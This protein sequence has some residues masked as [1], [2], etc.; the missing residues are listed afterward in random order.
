MK[1]QNLLAAIA[2]AGLAGCAQKGSSPTTF[3]PEPP[4]YGNYGN[5]REQIDDVLSDFGTLQIVVGNHGPGDSRMEAY[6]LFRRFVV[7]AGQVGTP[8]P[9]VQDTDLTNPVPKPGQIYIGTSANN[10]MIVNVRSGPLPPTGTGVIEARLTPSG[11][12]GYLVITA[13]EPSD[14]VAATR[15]VAAYDR[16]LADGSIPTFDGS[17]FY[18]QGT[19]DPLVFTVSKQ[20]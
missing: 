4:I 3:E 18:V 10:W 19:N 1:A 7:D 17:V 16:P 11:E 15:A 20:K 9:L 14:V 6:E 12:D 5:V 2:A 8:M 13:R